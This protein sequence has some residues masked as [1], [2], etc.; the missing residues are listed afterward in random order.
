MELAENLPFISA[1]SQMD[2]A[3]RLD[4]DTCFLSSAQPSFASSDGHTL[5][6]VS[7]TDDPYHP[8]IANRCPARFGGPLEE[9][10]HMASLGSRPCMCK[11]DNPR[12]DDRNTFF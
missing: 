12:S 6:V 5:G 4:P 8:E 9:G 2:R 3:A 7:L 11:A 10:D 1:M